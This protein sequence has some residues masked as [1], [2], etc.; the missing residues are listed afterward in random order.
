MRR[1]RRSRPHSLDRRLYHLV[2][3]L[4]H[5]RS[6]DQHLAIVSDLGKGAGW[7]AAGAWLALMDGRRGRRAGAAGAVSMLVAVGVCQGLLKSVYRRRRPF[8]SLTGAGLPAIV[9]GPTT[10][11]P[12]FPSAHTA[13]SFAAAAALSAFYPRHS[14][15]IVGAAASVGVS[16]VYLGHHFP[17]DVVAG[18]G[19]GAALGGLVAGLAGGFRERRR[20]AER[21]FSRLE[22]GLPAAPED[23]HPALARNS[24]GALP[25]RGG[26][27][28]QPE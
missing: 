27:L 8:A 26:P 28:I 23:G 10:D 4:P 15:L 3:G 5:T 21:L 22:H 1:L 13:G 24:P 19:I 7:V 25:K 6:G 2:N 17:S 16:R 14:P 20:D 11:D 9:V 18:A 12:S